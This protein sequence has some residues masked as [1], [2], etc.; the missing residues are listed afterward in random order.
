MAVTALIK[1]T[2]GAS[3]GNPGEV[4][5]GATGA[6]VVI[7]NDDNTDVLS[8]EIELLYVPPGSALF[9]GV[10]S[11][12]SSS[13]PA[14]SFTPDVSGSWRIRLKVYNAAGFTGTVDT[15]IRNFV[16]P[17]SKHG[18]VVPPYQKDPDPLPTLASGG[19]GA[20]PNEMNIN[21]EEFGWAGSGV[22]G[23]LQNFIKQVDASNF[24]LL[25]NTPAS[26][27]G[28]MSVFRD[29]PVAPSGVFYDSVDDELWWCDSG[30]TAVRR[31]DVSEGL[32][33]VQLANISL[34][35]V[36]R[37]V[38]TDATHAFVVHGSGTGAGATIIE[39]SS[40]TIVGLLAPGGGGRSLHSVVVNGD[41]IY[42][43][44][45]RGGT[46]GEIRKYSKAS[47]LAGYP[48][49]E[50]AGTITAN[51]NGTDQFEEIAIGGGKLWATD[52]A[53]QRVHKLNL[54]T[55]AH[56]GDQSVSEDTYGVLYAFGSVWALTGTY[57]NIL[58]FNPGTFPSVPTSS[59]QV[60]IVAVDVRALT[61]DS[62]YIYICDFGGGD[63][64]WQYDPGI[65]TVIN[66][67]N[68]YGA[69]DSLATDGVNI[70]VSLQTTSPVGSQGLDVFTI[71]T[72]TNDLSWL[73]EISLEYLALAGDVTG[74]QSTTT[75]EALQNIP[76]ISGTPTAGAAL[77]YTGSAWDTRAHLDY[78]SI[79]PGVVS[80]DLNGYV[81][82]GGIYFDPTAYQSGFLLPAGTII[83]FEALLETTNVA[84]SADLRLYNVTDATPVGTLTSTSLVTEFQTTN[85][86]V[87]TDIPLAA[88]VYEVQLRMGAGTAPD[89]VT[90]K[91]ARF[92]FST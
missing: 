85:L 41:D 90:C 55:V 92:R 88:K 43:V 18:L 7:A 78:L 16:I 91:M 3:V 13:T 82:I 80:T 26:P 73:G 66:N 17:E 40:N 52:A 31:L 81:A 68:S 2:Q 53:G 58:R 12:A 59:V 44:S 47:A 28:L 86:T 89:I 22:D 48:T 50:A 36:C 25:P 9:P 51:P 77:R 33:P 74:G 45:L 10:L 67:N 35:A 65:D 49:P 14:G 21:A 34:P 63:L 56:E 71:S 83:K 37:R 19:T 84:N 72:F 32:T 8:W 5:V 61:A 11:S 69:A 70:W 75:V 62:T 4:L 38:V 15:D 79:S 42:C 64:V 87:N 24:D 29:Q 54:T 46:P 23:M 27:G 60:S 57:Q 76:V 20:K 39:K 30:D 1:F 6:L